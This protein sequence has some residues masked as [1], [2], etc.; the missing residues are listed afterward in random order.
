MKKI[1]IVTTNRDKY[2]E[3]ASVLQVRGIE[4]EQLALEL[5][6]KE[7]T[8]EEIVKSKAEQAFAAA[9]KPVIVDDTGIFFEAFENFPGHRA[10]RVY[11]E[12]GYS[13]IL[14]KMKGRKRNAC[15]RSIIAYK[16]AGTLKLFA[17]R[18]KGTIAAEVRGTARKKFPYDA[19]FVPDGFD[20]TLSEIP[21]NERLKMSHRADAARKFAEWLRRKRRREPEK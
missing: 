8:L 6:E 15:F 18:L 17:G 9:G 4:A 16:D 19:I 20:V 12:L 10:K 7:E 13:G 21:W 14:E 2:E 1:L 5:E 3:I 11:K